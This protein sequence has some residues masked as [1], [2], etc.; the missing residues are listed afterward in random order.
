MSE[1]LNGKQRVNLTPEQ[2]ARNKKNEALLD[3]ALPIVLEEQKN[4]RF[5]DFDKAYREYKQNQ[6]PFKI[7]LGNKY[8]EIPRS[9]PASYFLWMATK[10]EKNDKNDMT[11]WS[12]TDIADAMTAFLPKAAVDYI[13]N[14]KIPVEF[15]VSTIIPQIMDLWQ[16]EAKEIKNDPKEAMTKDG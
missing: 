9:V 11:K 5:I 7:K 15:V 14:E 4:S 16:P 12:S 3:Q 8:F 10:A 6:V 13:F 2:E 1:V